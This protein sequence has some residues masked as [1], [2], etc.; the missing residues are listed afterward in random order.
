[1]LKSMPKGARFSN[2][3]RTVTPEK[4]WDCSSRTVS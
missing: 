4:F 1:M 3:W 2:F